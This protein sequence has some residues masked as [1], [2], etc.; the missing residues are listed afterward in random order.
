MKKFI[1]TALA[2]ASREAQIEG[3]TGSAKR[4]AQPPMP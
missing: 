3:L 4:T 1:D 2:V